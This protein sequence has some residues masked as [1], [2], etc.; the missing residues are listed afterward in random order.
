MT[1]TASQA[2]LL[3]PSM[4]AELSRR[5]SAPARALEEARVLRDGDEA[6]PVMLDL[7][8]SAQ[9]S[10][11]FENFIFAG[12]ATGLR[13]AKVLGEAARRG[14]EVRVL[15]DPV[16]TMMVKGG[17]IASALRAEVVTGR[18][19]R[20]VSPLAPWTWS[21][22]RHRDHR[23][24]LVV[25]G[26]TAVVGGLCISNNWAGRDQGGQNWRDTALLVRGPVAADV[27]V[28]FGSMWRRAAMEEVPAPTLFT[29]T[30]EV[31]CALVAADQP[32]AHHVASIYI[33][34][35]GHARHSLDITDA[36]LVT[37]E[38]V[39]AA[40]EAA[41]RRGVSVRF[42]LPGNNNHPAAAAS[43]RRRY[44]R[45]LAAGAR[46]YEW[47]G[48]MVHAKTA[49]ADGEI[50]IVGSSNLDPLSMTRNYELNLL[51]ADERT[52]GAMRQMFER[53]LEGAREV[54]AAAWAKRPLWQRA[55]ELAV[56]IFDGNL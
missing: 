42:L 6:F 40:L 52:G 33:W 9:R 8:R 10:V 38:P 24:T 13:F 37:P 35:A 27:S 3:Q 29:E 43:A 41:A 12:D 18:P 54:H 4:I 19:F 56:G 32:G 1:P 7:I 51:V 36:Y 5:A 46:I 21:R 44:A 14:V 25:D 15:Y 16:G 34:M 50:S 45:L 28:A 39:V 31:P 49:V 20:P 53:D 47:R 11:W 26:E 23:K 48:M 2:S 22:L 17:S 55:A 30:P